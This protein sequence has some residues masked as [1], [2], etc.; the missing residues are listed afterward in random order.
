[1]RRRNF[2]LSALTYIIL[3]FILY[4]NVFI[5][6]HIREQILQSN[7]LYNIHKIIICSNLV[8]GAFY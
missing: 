2:L 5:I 8:N 7:L 6:D 3:S 1:M 4:D